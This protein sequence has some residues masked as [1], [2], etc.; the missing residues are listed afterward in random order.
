M[1]IVVYIELWYIAVMS[2]IISLAS[3]FWLTEKDVNLCKTRSVLA[4]AAGSDRM[5][6]SLAYK[7]CRSAAGDLQIL[8]QTN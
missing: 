3:P 8:D 7:C 2:H 1:R 4:T 6:F 5:F